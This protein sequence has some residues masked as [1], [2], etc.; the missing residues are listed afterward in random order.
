MAGLL[1]EVFFPANKTGK[2]LSWYVEPNAIPDWIREPVI[3][4][5]QVGYMPSQKKV[6]VVEL[7]K[8]DKPQVTASIFKLD[9]NGKFVEKLKA[10]V[11]VWGKYLRYNYAQ[12][13]FSS[14]KRKRHL[15]YPI[16][17]AKN[18]HFPDCG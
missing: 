17:E 10:D 3:G 2:V 18:K 9:E 11:K 5:S 8:N 7:D 15:L 12:V 6:A 4:F 16:W 14:V 1:P 13:D